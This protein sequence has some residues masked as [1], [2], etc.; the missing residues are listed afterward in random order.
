MTLTDDGWLGY[1]EAG[2]LCLKSGTYTF[3]KSLRAGME[4]NGDGTYQRDKYPFWLKVG[5]GE[6][7]VTLKVKGT[8]GPVFGSSSVFVSDNAT[9]DFKDVHFYMHSTSSAFITNS[10]MTVN[11]VLLHGTSSMTISGSTMTVVDDLNV[12]DGSGENCIF[13]ADSTT[14]NLTQNNRVFNVG[15]GANSTGTVVKDGGDWSCYYLRLGT[16]SDSTGVFTHNE[17]TLEVKANSSE[18]TE[19]AI[20]NV[21]AGVFT[22]NGGNVTLASGINQYIGCNSGSSGMLNLN[23]GT[24]TARCLRRN[25]DGAT[26]MVNFNGGTLKSNYTD[27][28]GLIAAGVGVSVLSGGGTIDSGNRAISIAAAMTGTGAMKFKGGNT[29]TLTGANTYTGGTTLELGTKLVASNADAKSAVL[30]NS[31]VIDGRAVL[32]VKTYDVLEAS[33]LTAADT[34]NITLVNCA[35]GS[36]VGFDDDENPTKIVVTLAEPVCVNTASPILAFPDKTIDE[37]KEADFT[38]RFFGLSVASKFEALDSAKSYNKKF[39]FSGSSLSSIVV[40]FQIIDNETKCVVVEF[41]NGG[42][43]VYAKALGARYKAIGT[44]LG[45]VFL[46]QDKSTWHG[47]QNTVSTSPSVAAYGVCDFICYS[48]SPKAEWTLDANKNWSDFS[49]HDT[50]AADD[51]VRIT[52]TGDYTLTMDT[53][54][55]VGKIEFMGASGST[56]NVGEGQT[57]TAGGISGIGYISNGGTIITGMAGGV[58]CIGH[59]ANSGTIVKTGEGAD[60]LPFDNASTGVTI[61][62]NGTL[63]VARV[64]P[65]TGGNTYALIPDGVNQE[66]RVATGATFDLCGKN[67]LTVSVRLADGANFANTGAAIENSKMQTVQIILDGDATATFKSNFGLI[68]P[69]YEP[70]RLELGS[71]TFTIDGANVHFWLCKATITGDGTIYVYHGWL[72]PV[73]NASTGENCT[74]SVGD[75]GGLQL[76]ANLTVSN[77]V[78]GAINNNIKGGS[79]LTVKGQLTPGSVAI[80]KLTLAGGA[81]I[82]ATGT[83]QRV[84][85]T[86]SASGTITIDVSDISR[87]QLNAAGT[88]I[89]VLT[90]PSSS[91]TTSAAWSVSGARAR[92]RW[93]DDAGGTTKTLFLMRPPGMV[94][95]VM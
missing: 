46:E 91:D 89:P 51:Y 93:V 57:V 92:C 13:K 44:P 59:I 64:T 47:T 28:R 58:S 10:T 16:G 5:D 26:A 81:T 63:K 40:E 6:S 67:D 66:V 76:D 78:N 60:C 14:L 52:A 84:T 33:G 37:I 79:T 34:N 88:G 53:D 15:Y 12:A 17:G 73:H 49:G 72:H 29:I 39:Y 43:G 23:G 24:L 82:K 65:K 31:L 56:M 19:I 74:V 21:G 1:Y 3:R 20:G 45:T 55:I 75:G 86:F 36:T 30:D 77:F 8:R 18:T 80:P 41:T 62:S 38:S 95:F 4:A 94:V 90:V 2:W 70:T 35:A 83:A 68:A 42:G 61:V 54:V 87:E 25:N 22:L 48:A 11:K 69:N 27:S 7:D 32:E 50:L 85:T 9:L 71:N